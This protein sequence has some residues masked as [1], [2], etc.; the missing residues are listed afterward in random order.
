MSLFETVPQRAMAPT[1]KPQVR[2]HY[3]TPNQLFELTTVVFEGDNRLG[4]VRKDTAGIEQRPAPPDSL[5]FRASWMPAGVSCN[6]KLTR[7]GNVD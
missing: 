5:L 6:F 2:G 1:A 7:D 3:P 4:A